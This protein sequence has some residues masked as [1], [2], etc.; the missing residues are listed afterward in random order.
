ME[1]LKTISYK[2]FQ[3]ID[4]ELR[5]MQKGK[6]ENDKYLEDIKEGIGQLESGHDRLESGHENI[7]AKVDKVQDTVDEGF[8]L[9][10]TELQAY[11]ESMFGHILSTEKKAFQAS[12]K[13]A[14]YVQKIEAYIQTLSE[15]EQQPFKG[16]QHKES[17]HKLKMVLSLGVTRYER[18]YDMSDAKWPRTW[19][20]FKDIFRYKEADTA[21]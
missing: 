11:A 16:W 10:G 14:E 4:E 19:K 3:E 20:D 6:Y 15:K 21:G 8:L 7:F 13:D 12:M 1:L 5:R 18:E 2:T 17:K 9:L